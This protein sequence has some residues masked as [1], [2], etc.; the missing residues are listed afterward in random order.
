LRRA[1]TLGLISLLLSS[2][3][4]LADVVWKASDEGP[5]T[6]VITEIVGDDTRTIAV[7]VGSAA[8]F[9][10][11]IW[12]PVSLNTDA[13]LPASRQMFAAS[14]QIAAV[15][16]QDNTLRLF[17]LRG[18]E[19]SLAA[20]LPFGYQSGGFGRPSLFV[21]RGDDRIYVPDL[22]FNSCSVAGDCPA[23][24]SARH[25]RSIS[26]AD[27]SIREEPDLPACWGLLFTVSNR[28]YLI[29]YSQPA[30]GGPS[31]RTGA[32]A[33]T[34]I[35]GL[36]FFR[37]DGDR[38][39]ALDPWTQPIPFAFTQDAAWVVVQGATAVDRS[40]MLLTSQGFS[41]PIPLSPEQSSVSLLPLEW[42]GRNLVFAD[43]LYEVRDGSL[44]PFAPACPVQG[45]QLFAAGK[46]LFAWTEGWNVFT[47]GDADWEETFGVPD[48]PGGQVYLGGRTKVFAIRGNRLFR[49]DDPGWVSLPSPP[50]PPN[51]W[52]SQFVCLGDDLVLVDG[53]SSASYGAYRYDTPS[54][55][56][57]NLHLP[58]S[59]T[60]RSLVHQDDLYVGGGYNGGEGAAVW[61]QGGWTTV[62]TGAQVWLLRE[63]N[64]SVYA[65]GCRTGP[66]ESSVC[67]IDKGQAVQAF[68]GMDPALSPVDV[69]GFDGR[70]LVS[71]TDSSA[72]SLSLRRALVSDASEAYRTLLRAG[73]FWGLRY[74]TT[75]LQLSLAPVDGQLLF[76]SGSYGRGQLRAQRSPVIPSI[77][78][79]SGR[80]AFRDITSMEYYFYRGPLLVPTVRVRKNLAAAVDATGLGGVRYRSELHVANF[81]STLSAV[82]RVFAGARQAPVLEIPLG[83][84]VQATIEDPVPGFL[85]PAAV[86]FDGL[87]DEE[88][89]WA[90]IRVWSQSD[91]GSASTSLIGTNPGDMAGQ[92]VV[93]PPPSKPGSRTHAA[94]SASGDGAGGPMYGWAFPWGSSSYLSGVGE[95]LANGGFFQ[96]DFPQAS[97]LAPVVVTGN[98][99]GPCYPLGSV[100]DLGAYLVRNEEGTNDG[101]I[102]PLE[103]P[104]VMEGRL[105]RFLPALV[106]LSSG[107]GTY[108]TEMAL[109]WRSS[110]TYP[111][112]NLEFNVTF[113]NA[114]GAWTVPISIPSYQSLQIA[115]AGAWLVANGVPVDPAN[116]DG[117]LTFT[118]DREEGAA[119]L[120]ITAIVTA[121]GPGA[122]GDYGVSVPV[123]NEV[124]WASTQAIVPGLREDPAFRSNLA[125]AN[126]EPEGGPPV[127]V[128]VSLRRASDGAPIGVFP[129]VQLVPG[130]RVQLNQPL[131]Q[132]GYGG[133]GY[134]VI[135]RAAGTGRFV[136]YGVVNDN[137]TG[138]G[139]L[140]PMTGAK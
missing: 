81:S 139:T 69:V 112:L 100:D 136:A 33:K 94:L 16:T 59:F 113:R 17:F 117:T 55:Q 116:V 103:R 7:T 89:A 34:M 75:D 109:A 127:T 56:W 97:L 44:V 64:G 10:G 95:N 49:K 67:R 19:W 68:P 39:T 12:H 21:P 99:R 134:A 128:S 57:V 70:T 45:E 84:G 119:D 1:G 91:G 5:R 41:S 73:D 63:A 74:G 131:S 90:A 2:G 11:K 114:A 36:P 22:A 96:G 47:L 25:L 80:F 104:D 88:D 60:G 40:L 107:W 24:D 124:Q 27:G 3:S 4:L 23:A 106:S 50:S 138:D 65:F 92:T 83:P 140:F 130:Q 123:F 46:R 37:L 62:P 31:T 135:T 125:V 48:I 42:D 30:C 8:E 26:L 86:E 76:Q 78:D 51:L 28:L 66:T 118:S 120:L 87:V 15:S 108:R 132:V 9:D 53:G 129:P 111:P 115:D 6:P 35:A 18:T 72:R 137:V 77:I 85:G 14:G 13:V 20:T 98:C 122:S 133:E 93:A 126:P 32:K 54:G 101:A 43:K 29:Q 71:V 61:H 121:R 52:S 79:P 102:V 58:P 110:E 82:A 38:W 105:T